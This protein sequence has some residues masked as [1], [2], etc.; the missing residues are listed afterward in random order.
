MEKWNNAKDLCSLQKLQKAGK[1]DALGVKHLK[2]LKSWQSGLVKSVGKSVV[3]D[4]IS[5]ALMEGLFNPNLQLLV[6]EIV[7]KLEGKIAKKVE[8]EIDSALLTRFVT[9]QLAKKN[10]NEEN[11]EDIIN[12]ALDQAEDDDRAKTISKEIALG[13]IRGTNNKG[14]AIAKSLQFISGVVDAALTRNELELD[15]YPR[16]F[17]N[18]FNIKLKDNNKSEKTTSSTHKDDLQKAIKS[19]LKEQFK[20]FLLK[21]IL[22]Q[23][24]F[25]SLQEKLL[26]LFEQNFK[27]DIENLVDEILQKPQIEELSDKQ[28]KKLIE[29]QLQNFFLPTP[30]KSYFDFCVTT[31]DLGHLTYIKDCLT[32]KG[33][34]EESFEQCNKQLEKYYVGCFKERT[35]DEINIQYNVISAK[36]YI[37][38]TILGQFTGKITGFISKYSN[39]YVINPMIHRVLNFK[40]KKVENNEI[41]HLVSKKLDNPQDVSSEYT[42]HLRE[43]GVGPD[44]SYQEIR[45]SYIKLC[46]E[47]HPDKVKGSDEHAIQARKE[48][49]EKIKKIINARDYLTKDKD[50]ALHPTTHNHDDTNVHTPTTESSDAS[51]TVNTTQPNSS[52]EENTNRHKTAELDLYGADTNDHQL[53]SGESNDQTNHLN[54]IFQ[55]LRIPSNFEHGNGTGNKRKGSQSLVDEGN[56]KVMKAAINNHEG[57]LKVI[58]C[59]LSS[60][61]YAM[62]TT[63]KN[64]QDEIPRASGFR[65]HEFK[66]NL[67]K[68]LNLK[69]QDDVYDHVVEFIGGQVDKKTWQ[70]NILDNI[71]RLFF[72]EADQYIT[73][74]LFLCFRRSDGSGHMVNIERIADR[75][76]RIIDSQTN[77]IITKRDIPEDNLAQYLK[78][79]DVL[80]IH[81]LGMKKRASR[82]SS[83]T[84][85]TIHQN[86]QSTLKVSNPY[87]FDPAKNSEILTMVIKPGD[88]GSCIF[89]AQ[90]KYNDPDQMLVSGGIQSKAP[91]TSEQISPQWTQVKPRVEQQGAYINNPRAL[92]SVAESQPIYPNN[93]SAAGIEKNTV[94]NLQVKEFNKAIFMLKQEGGQIGVMSAYNCPFLRQDTDNFVKLQENSVTVPLHPGANEPKLMVTGT[95]SGC[96]LIIGVGEYDLRIFHDGRP[97]DNREEKIQEIENENRQIMRLEHADNAEDSAHSHS[98]TMGTPSG[99]MHKV[100]MFLCYNNASKKWELIKQ[101][102]SETITG[103]SIAIRLEGF[104]TI[105]IPEYNDFI[106]SDWIIDI[107]DDHT[108]VID[109]MGYNPDLTTM[110]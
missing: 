105:E 98:Y 13:T 95:F 82:Y 12:E 39:T 94:V 19:L 60:I 6:S 79:Q 75:R 85:D 71:D 27:E 36:A 53:N 73:G 58:N 91:G 52:Q 77:R 17:C 97:A 37:K 25:N 109:I 56:Q 65:I 104:K 46:Q 92:R 14:N 68:I 8:E 44:A 88:S 35:A 24:T 7:K 100:T 101:R 69:R 34:M 96:S 54:N 81:L 110:N 11:I 93:Q 50:Q 78:K 55:N 47:H 38:E 49:T 22:Y 21:Y 106:N 41:Q 90:G 84:L 5:T 10:N 29:E 102:V 4:A 63:S 33:T 31:E 30:Q 87:N 40:F 48:S 42:D 99:G 72:E 28:F 59:T 67:V 45:K 70:N 86:K 26:N 51:N 16:D 80:S 43:L 3:Q 89:L 83:D 2:A 107:P 9:E 74:P 57:R 18:K 66:T 62:N 103:G 15:K 76:I 1:L 20:N 64:V 61:A 23:N 108:H 32:F